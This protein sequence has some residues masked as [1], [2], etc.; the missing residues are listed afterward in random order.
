M[1]HK[2]AKPRPERPKIVKGNLVHFLSRLPLNRMGHRYTRPWS[3]VN[4]AQCCRQ[5]RNTILLQHN[6]SHRKSPPF[7][8]ARHLV[9]HGFMSFGSAKEVCL[10]AVKDKISRHGVV[11]SG[12]TSCHKDAAWHYGTPWPCPSWVYILVQVFCYLPHLGAVFEG[13]IGHLATTHQQF[14]PEYVWVR[15]RRAE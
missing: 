14:D 6:I 4:K 2:R 15:D 8:H 13:Q 3:T 9:L 7:A 10:Q 1:S 5:H 12:S 11:S